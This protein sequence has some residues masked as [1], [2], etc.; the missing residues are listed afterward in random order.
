MYEAGF[1]WILVGFE[2]GHPR[3][4]ENIQKKATR[5]ENTRCMD[6]ARRHN[7]KVKALMSVGHPG[8]S[9][10]TIH[11]TRDWLVEVRP[12]DFDAT[13]ITTYPGTPY[14]DEAVETAPGI[15][16]Y[17]CPKSQD[18]LHSVEVD[19]RHVAEYYKGAPGNYT[20]FIYTDDLTS[21]QLVSYRDRLEND[22]RHTLSIPFNSANQGLSY[23][24]SMGQ[25]GLPLSI[26]R[27]SDPA[28]TRLTHK[29]IRVFS[30]GG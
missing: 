18:R 11:A 23:E 22:V 28:A 19:Y 14:F 9:E 25:S 27:T 2:S 21:T 30:S 26:L 20:A 8:E 4:L 15:W 24:H 6:I 29:A 7:L 12:D 3:I 1:R 16:T 17:T 13:V 5:D 10:E